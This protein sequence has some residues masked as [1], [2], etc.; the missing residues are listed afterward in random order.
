MRPFRAWF[1]RLAGLFRKESRDRDFS[2][3]LDSNLALHIEENLRRGMNPAEARRQALIRLGSVEA[4]KEEHRDR[5]G[6]PWLEALAQDVR[7]GFRMLRKN[8]GFTAVAVITLALGIGANSAVFSV[9]NGVLLK[10]LPYPD[11]ERLVVIFLRAAGQDQSVLGTADFLALHEHQNAFDAV[12][13][14][15]PSGLGFALSGLGSPR[16]IPGT[17]VSTDFFRVLGTHPALG[18]D[19]REEEGKE[20]GPLAVVVSDHFWRDVLGS[21]PR[22]VGRKIRLDEKLYAIVGVMPAGFHFGAPADLWPAIQ[23]HPENRRPPYG[24]YVIGR[25]KPGISRPQADDDVTRIAAAVQKQF[26]M[27]GYDS[28]VT[29]PMKGFFVNE[30]REGLFLLLGAVAFVLLIAVVNVAS[31]QLSRAA[32]RGREM[33]VRTALGAGR[34]RLVRQLLT[35]S[36]M[37]ATVG[38]VAGIGVALAGVRGMLALS[39]DNLPRAE[40][41]SVDLP[42]LAFTA[43]VALLAGV[44]F[45]LAPLLH[46]FVASVSER[47]KGESHGTTAGR[48]AR[49]PHNVLVVAEFSLALVVLAGAGLLIQTLFRTQAV[50]PGFEPRRVFTALISLPRPRY[51][52]PEQLTSFY[53]RLIEK[54]SKSPGVEGA[55]IALSLP[56]NL[57]ELTN[58]FHLEGHPEDRSHPDP[59]VVEVPI[60]DGYFRALGVPLLRGR[61][62]NDSDRGSNTHVLIINDYMARKYF[63][64]QDPVGQ[65]V[66]TGE[67]SPNADLDTIV[68]VVGNVKYEGLAAE[69]APAMYVPYHDSGWCPWF[70]Q[71]MYVVVR[72]AGSAENAASAL[73]SAMK[74]IDPELPIVRQRTMEELIYNSVA[75]SR[76]RAILFGLFAGLSLLLAATGIYGVIAYSVSQRTREIG[77]RMAM[78]AERANVFGMVLKGALRLVLAGVAIGLCAAF[79]LAR[80]M[81]SLLFGVDARDPAALGGAAILLA[82]VALV[83]SMIPARRATR[84]SPTLALRGE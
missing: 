8:P 46:S 12:A 70:V 44:L 67:H 9:V 51:S 52:K 42:V 5:R 41:V 25:L 30:Q 2:A 60:S 68:G 15:S 84:I 50:N 64:G 48:S 61:Y 4:V 58:P 57:L 39:G 7:F 13:A 66:S 38:G 77:V 65:R 21:D 72:S 28:A 74:S 49:R 80:L 17:S 81:S 32:A 45:G 35:E 26:P 3:E 1:S 19:F 75:G 37:L 76:F 71:N 40:D 16:M 10:P 43:A 24:W 29:I 63:P 6:V 56:P 55:A 82:L 27:S 34:G 18:R 11:P 59:A 36:V 47:L 73:R 78:G 83:A 33:A 23:V 54:L 62:F 31:L 20:G 79:L 53:D 69:D 22:A 14:Y